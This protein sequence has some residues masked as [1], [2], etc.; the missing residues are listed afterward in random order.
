MM[1]NINDVDCEYLYDDDYGLWLFTEYVKDKWND[2]DQQE[3]CK[4]WTTKPNNIKLNAHAVLCDLYDTIENDY[5]IEDL[6]E[7]LWEDTT[8]DFVM[9]FQSMLDEI[10]AFPSSAFFAQDEKI[11][12]TID[13]EEE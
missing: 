13:L 12:P 10:C 11:D 6:R 3:R 5:D 4:Y 7:R 2:M 1:I 8:K 9:R